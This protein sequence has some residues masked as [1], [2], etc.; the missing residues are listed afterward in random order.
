MLSTNSQKEEQETR[1]KYVKSGL[2]KDLQFD[3][4][5]FSTFNENK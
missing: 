4:C 3:I 5:I 2:D 1:N